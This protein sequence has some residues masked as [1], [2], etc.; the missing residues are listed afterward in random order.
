MI[1]KNNNIPL[2]GNQDL[3][4]SCGHCIAICPTNAI[5]HEDFSKDNT[6]PINQKLLP[7]INELNELF[8]SRRSIRSFKNKPVE[9]ELIK[10]AIEGARFAPST[11]NLQSTKYIIVQDKEIIN[12][13]IE[14]TKDYINK[15]I[16][17]FNNP[18]LRKIFLF[19]SKNDSNNFQNM[20]RDYKEIIKSI[21]HGNEIILHNAPALL[22]FYANKK[23]GFSDVNAA[24]ALQNATLAL[25]SIG[26]GS[27]YAGYLVAAAKKSENIG[28]LLNIPKNHEIYGCLAI[29]YPKLKYEKWIE[30]KK[31]DIKWV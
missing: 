1:S 17:T 12:Q 27:F 4:V 8:K 26:L 6:H 15:I 29:G 5:I 2:I 3:C 30:R 10:K 14:Y 21:R 13:L 7:Q 23:I 31:P 18:I 9:K 28:K 16:K 20:V 25:F 22:F 19:Y 24:L 11:N